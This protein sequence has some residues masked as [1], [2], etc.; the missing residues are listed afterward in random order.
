[1]AERFSTD[2]KS[3]VGSATVN[4]KIKIIAEHAATVLID[5]L[6]IEKDQ[7]W[8]FSK[9]EQLEVIDRDLDRFIKKYMEDLKD[10]LQE[11]ATRFIKRNRREIIKSIRKF[12]FSIYT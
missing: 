2:L 1:M 9:K 11:N 5:W 10:I 4:Q 7:F 3:T 8:D 12:V 6:N